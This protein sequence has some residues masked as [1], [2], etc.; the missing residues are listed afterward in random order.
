M[1]SPQHEAHV[2]SVVIKKPVKTP[3]SRSKRIRMQRP[4]SVMSFCHTDTWPEHIHQTGFNSSPFKA[5]PKSS[6]AKERIHL[7]RRTG[8]DARVAHYRP[9]VFMSAVSKGCKKSRNNASQLAV[10][11][12][13]PDNPL[14]S[15]NPLNK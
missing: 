7:E 10:Q 11:C 1:I 5:L 9:I 15:Q 13:R 12:H 2:W 6:T 14:L 3:T 4:A 8:E